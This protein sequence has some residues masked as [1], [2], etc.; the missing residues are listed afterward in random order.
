MTE[1]CILGSN[2]EVI[3]G[4]EEVGIRLPEKLCLL[5]ALRRNYQ[6]LLQSYGLIDLAL[7]WHT[8]LFEVLTCYV[9]LLCCI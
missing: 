9:I 5:H 2:A 3:L 6:V 7:L 4:K 8:S 1:Y